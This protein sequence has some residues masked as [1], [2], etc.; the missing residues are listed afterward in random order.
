MEILSPFIPP[1]MSAIEKDKP[2]TMASVAR[3][4]KRKVTL[5]GSGSLANAA[6]V[7]FEREFDVHATFQSITQQIL[8]DQRQLLLIR[9]VQI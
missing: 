7:K 4:G 8:E 5:D 9:P 6:F 1:Q 2:I 3:W